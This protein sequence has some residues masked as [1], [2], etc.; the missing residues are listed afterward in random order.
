[1][2]RKEYDFSQGVR[3]KFYRPGVELSLPVYLEPDVA[4]FVVELAEA[5]DMAGEAIVNT[6]LRQDIALIEERTMPQS[7]SAAVPE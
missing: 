3:S 5:K 4:K 7:P 2:M 1:M 6:W